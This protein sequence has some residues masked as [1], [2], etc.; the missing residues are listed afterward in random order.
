MLSDA[1]CAQ[2]FVYGH[3]ASEASRAADE[4]EAAVAEAAVKKRAAALAL[5]AAKEATAS[6][7]VVQTSSD[8]NELYATVP[9]SSPFEV[10]ANTSVDAD[11][12]AET[13]M[14]SSS[15]CDGVLSGRTGGRKSWPVPKR[16]LC[17]LSLAEG[18]TLRR[19]LHLQQ[20][21]QQMGAGTPAATPAG[22]SA[23]AGGGSATATT[24]LGPGLCLRTLDG[25]PSYALDASPHFQSFAPN[26]QG[27]TDQSACF[28]CLRFA[29]CEM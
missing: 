1:F 23:A 11:A 14:G 16:F 4:A 21:Q 27:E 17:V 15:G 28:Q 9:D 2:A 24:W 3:L 26:S 12:D 6:S 20:Q 19:V 25:G 13:S 22:V 29:N 8:N 5:A 10:A 18:E 7:E